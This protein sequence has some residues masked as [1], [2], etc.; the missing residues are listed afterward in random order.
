MVECEGGDGEEEGEDVNGS[1]AI[2]GEGAEG[3]HGAVNGDA[4]G[5]VG[6]EGEVG[7]LQALEEGP[8]CAGEVVDKCRVAAVVLLGADDE[9]FD[10]GF[11]VLGEGEG[12]GEL[13]VG[14]GVLADG[15]LE[16]IHLDEVVGAGGAFVDIGR[17]IALEGGSDD[18]VVTAFGGGGAEAV[19]GAEIV[20]HLLDPF[21]HVGEWIDG[22]GEEGVVNVG[23]EGDGGGDAGGVEGH[24]G[25][26]FS[27]GAVV[28]VEV[29]VAEEGAAGGV[30]EFDGL[31]GAVEGGGEGGVDRNLNGEGG[32]VV[33]LGLLDGEA[34]L[35]ALAAVDEPFV[36]TGKAIGGALV[37][38]GA[39][40]G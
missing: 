29:A 12:G 2:L 15:N 38:E 20:W 26:E 13:V 8:D 16:F 23:L 35:E 11:L 25:G 28:D 3:D 18:E 6:A 1:L 9:V 10:A 14:A 27:S 36:A 17:A 21:L 22:D 24:G 31:G 30:L 33:A 7:G 32:G 34:V 19:A 39:G 5:E 4:A 40:C 37:F